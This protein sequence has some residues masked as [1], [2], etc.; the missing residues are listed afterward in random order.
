MTPD[1]PYIFTFY[2]F[3]GGVGRSMALLNIAHLLAERGRHVLILDLDLEAPGVSHFLA[4]REELDDAPADALDII[5]LLLAT[6]PMAEAKIHPDTSAPKLMEE[7]SIQRLRRSVRSEKAL[8][9]KYAPPGRIDVI[10]ACMDDA[11]WNRL[12]QL[13]LGRTSADDIQRMGLILREYV[14]LQ[15]FPILEPGLLGTQEPLAT[16]YDYVLVD[17]RTGITEVGG[18]CVGALSDRLV[19]CTG[20]NQQNIDGTR[21]FFKLVGIELE[22]RKRDHFEPFDDADP[23]PGDAHT[24]ELRGP[25]PTLLVVSPVPTGEIA[26]KRDRLRELEDTL[27]RRAATLSY[28]PQL[29]V[30]ESI[31]VRDY[32]EE[33]LSL[34]YSILLGKLMA[35][36][37][38]HLPQ[39]WA[40]LN[41][42]ASDKELPEAI[43]TALRIDATDEDM[44]QSLLSFVLNQADDASREHLAALSVLVARLARRLEPDGSDALTA[45][46]TALAMRAEHAS[47]KDASELFDD[48]NAAFEQALSMN[49]NQHEAMNNW[50][51]ALFEQAKRTPEPQAGALFDAA[52][53]KYEQALRIKPD[54][55]EALYNWGNTLF[56]K[57]KRTP[58]PQA[59][60][61]FD[62]ACAK[63]EQAIRIKPDEHKAFYNW[64]TTLLEQ[65][66]R[67]PAPQDDALIEAACAKY[68]Q[69]IR[70]KPDKHEALSN[71]G[72]ALFQ[73]AVRAPAPHAE[74]LF[75]AACVKYEQALRIE[76]DSHDDLYNWANAL[77]AKAILVPA[78]HGDALLEAACAKYEQALRIKTDMHEALHNWGNTLLEQATRASA[79][80]ANA[81]FDVACAKYEQALRIKPDKNDALINW[82]R[83]L[84]E[85]SKR[86]PGPHAEALLD[87]ACAKYEQALR[88]EPFS[89]DALENWGIAVA[90]KAMRAPAAL[91]D[92]LYETALA[93]LGAALALS[94]KEASVQFNIACVHALRGDL[95]ACLDALQKCA[96]DIAA[97]AKKIAEDSDFDR[98]REDPTFVE[99]LESL[100]KS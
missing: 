16:P 56:E 49:P 41:R 22:A 91:A 14:R 94:R 44:G 18:L 35:S 98:V 93:K 100:P 79:S 33:Y 3:K 27:G 42:Q 80:Q 52:S 96:P 69:A 88:V 73:Q 25:K 86:A 17:S 37:G 78:R 19:V 68:E 48:A 63:Y 30:L 38:D 2:S 89:H 20:L 28:H 74:A 92:G 26:A 61:L 70:I 10:P 58:M 1:Y 13:D 85:Q 71:W 84:L 11:Y 65:A 15:R 64:G 50:G 51:N 47:T 54:K 82:G 45:W 7:C 81:L 60:E 66:E 87:A 5:D 39:L 29:A 8:A 97:L 40:R 76:P 77:A 72:N 62:A 59:N 55:H 90:A 75:D 43:H 53:A 46:G 95:Q 83:T 34:E 21:S 67:V 31:F 9:P 99:F 32:P 36:V 12:S 6:K 4:A 23:R 57:A 24:P